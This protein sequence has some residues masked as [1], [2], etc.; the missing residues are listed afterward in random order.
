MLPVDN[1]RD[2]V[3]GILTIDSQTVAGIRGVDLHGVFEEVAPAAK[4]GAV[5]ADF[6]WSLRPHEAD[7]LGVEEWVLLTRDHM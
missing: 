5:E 2:A 3:A 7:I 6:V 4:Q 1:H